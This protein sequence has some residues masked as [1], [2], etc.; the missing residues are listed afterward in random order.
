MVILLYPQ[1]VRGS[2]LCRRNGNFQSDRKYR[3]SLSA[4]F[5]STLICMQKHNPLLCS[6]ML[7]VLPLQFHNSWFA[8]CSSCVQQSLCLLRS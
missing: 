5:T 1:Q 8:Y 6:Y 4:S 2:K 3:I 7:N